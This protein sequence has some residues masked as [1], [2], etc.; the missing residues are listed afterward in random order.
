MPTTFITH[1][2]WVVVLGEE[3]R[4]VECNHM[5][6][7]THWAHAFWFAEGKITGFRAYADSG[8]VAEALVAA[9]R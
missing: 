6:Y 3:R 4:R 7:D 8:I 5:R 2:E 1:G 9:A